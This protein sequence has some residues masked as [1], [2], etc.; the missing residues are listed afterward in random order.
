MEN[1]AYLVRG[2]EIQPQPG[3]DHQTHMQIHGAM[4]TQVPEFQQLNPQQQQL[5]I[6][7]RD[8]HMQAHQQLINQEGTGAGRQSLPSE[9]S[10]AT[11]LVSVTR[12]NAQNVANATQAQVEANAQ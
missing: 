4:E 9:A 10:S 5:A 3:E 12:S 11:N 2:G 8:A 6:Q 7:A 1:T